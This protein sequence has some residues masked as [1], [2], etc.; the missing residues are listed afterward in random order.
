MAEHKHKG[1]YIFSAPSGCGKTSLAHA[2]IAKRQDMALSVSHTTRAIRPGEEHGLDYYFIEKD[3]FE[4]MIEQSQFLEHAKVYD[5]LYGTAKSETR[6]LNDEGKHVI[7]DIDWQGAQQV[8]AQCD[9]VSIFIMPPSLACLKKRLIARGQDSAQVIERRMQDARNQ[10]SHS[11][12]FDHI[13]V[14]D[15]FAHSLAA[16]E[17]II[18]SA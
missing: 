8:R 11:D 7:L 13:I 9:A 14:N 10:M 16:L 5:Y 2:L 3:Q 6:R 1:I 17:A 4:L 15:D 18:D 12:E